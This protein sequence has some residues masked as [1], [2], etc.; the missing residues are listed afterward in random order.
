MELI[1]VLVLLWMGQAIFITQ[2]DLNVAVA[3]VGALIMGLLQLAA[4]W[5]FRRTLPQQAAA[6]I[7]LIP[8]IGVLARW[9]LFTLTAGGLI[10]AASIHFVPT[11]D[12]PF[13]PLTHHWAGWSVAVLI[14]PLVEEILFRACVFE[15]LRPRFSTTV[16]LLISAAVFGL[17]HGA[18]V[19]IAFAFCAGL[20][21]GFAY[22]RSGSILP[23]FIGHAVVNAMGL[24][25]IRHGAG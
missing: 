11:L 21:F 15:L 22:L 1:L 5:F 16:A 8:H 19:S 23:S 9:T 24:W 25:T 18:L 20:V 10:Q 7:R 12:L 17:A 3:V 2:A 14:A 4:L 6:S 13:Q